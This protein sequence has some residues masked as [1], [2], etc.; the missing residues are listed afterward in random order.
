MFSIIVCTFNRVDTLKIMLESFFG[1]DGINEIAYELLVVDNNSRIE[2]RAM[3]DAFLANPRCHYV[4]EGRQ[5]L[6]FAR[7]RGVREA[8][9]EILAFLDDDVIVD[10]N[11]LE[12][13]QRC[14]LQTEAD[15]VGGRVYLSF[16]SEPPS[17]LGIGFRTALSEVN[18]G[19]RRCLADAGTGLWGLNLSIRRSAFE[20]AG[21]FDERLGRCGLKLL[22]NEDAAL[23]QRIACQGKKIVY[24]P[25]VVVG[26]IIRQARLDWKYFAAQ[27]RGFGQSQALVDPP[28]PK[29]YQFLRV[30][31]ALARCFGAFFNLAKTFSS[32]SSLYEKRFAQWT[33]I[34]ETSFLGGRLKQLGSRSGEARHGNR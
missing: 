31:K 32:G 28:R 27:A 7:N 12:N 9:G 25:E 16:E 6:S 33:L 2:T 22:A 15:A 34:K 23:L 4:F 30:G 21:G 5:G 10:R 17:W 8:K 1:Q 24:E 14:Y 13:L 29:G 26:H 3:A 20:A 19:N 18:L 11:W